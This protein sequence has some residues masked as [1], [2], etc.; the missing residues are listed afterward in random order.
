MLIG[1]EA[2]RTV[3]AIVAWELAKPTVT[4][5]QRERA[6]ARLSPAPGPPSGRAG[7]LG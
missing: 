7:D 4:P 5:V 2:D 1:Q 6:L 3:N